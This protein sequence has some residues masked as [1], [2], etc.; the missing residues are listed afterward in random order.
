LDNEKIIWDF[1]YEKI[2]NPYGV[3]GLMGNLYVESRFDSSKLQNTYSRK[4]GISSSEYTNAVDK[5]IYTDFVHDSAGYG[6]VQWTYWSRKEGLYNY[7]K[8]QN[9]SIGDLQTQLDYIWKEI[10]TYKT[11]IN[12]LKSAKSVK[13][14]SDIVVE[15]YEKPTDQSE[16]AKQNRAAYGEQIFSKHF[17]QTPF[18]KGEKSSKN[19]IVTHDRVN[20][21]SGNGKE[22]ARISLVN[23]G[24]SFQWVATA[25]NGWHAVKLPKQIGWI[26]GEFSKINS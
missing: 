4:L 2:G 1:L 9:K 7:A 10:Q 19:V 11:C 21:R 15:R 3:A 13:E 8:S 6:L 26:S 23:K 22:F 17:S 12:T 14:A 18:V 16:K 5:G 24:T 25:E 20:V